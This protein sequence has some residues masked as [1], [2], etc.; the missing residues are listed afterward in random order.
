MTDFD[1]DRFHS[2]SLDR[3]LFLKK[4]P[5]RR[6]FLSAIAVLL[7]LFSCLIPMFSSQR[8]SRAASHLGGATG[9]GRV[10]WPLAFMLGFVSRKYFIHFG[11]NLFIY[12]GGRKREGEKRFTQH[13]TWYL[14]LPKSTMRVKRL[15]HNSQ[16]SIPGIK[17]L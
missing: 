1:F 17:N 14:S 3:F 7:G 13:F 10:W 15:S 8:D 16:Y 6:K 9:A 4:I 12:T 2:H 5:T 11:N